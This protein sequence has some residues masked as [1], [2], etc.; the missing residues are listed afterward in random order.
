MIYELVTWSVWVCAE[1]PGSDHSGLHG[2]HHLCQVHGSPGQGRD[3]H[4]LQKR[5][6]YHEERC[7]LHTMQGVRPQEILITWGSYQVKA[8]LVCLN[9]FQFQQSIWKTMKSSC[10]TL[11]SLR[12]ELS[13]L[14]NHPA[15]TQKVKRLIKFAEKT[16]ENWKIQFKFEL[17]YCF[18]SVLLH[19]D[20]WMTRWVTF[21][22]ADLT[23]AKVWHWFLK[24]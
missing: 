3:H 15:M 8:P 10:S 9:F 13:F 2:G 17:L 14:S 12:L 18:C 6:D 19:I 21:D 22:P 4:F 11:R 23:K 1:Y 20:Y 7:S 24:V 16:K 5:C